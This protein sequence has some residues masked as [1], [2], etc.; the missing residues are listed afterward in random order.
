PPACQP[1]IEERP[2]DFT[3]SPGHMALQARA[4]E[5]TEKHLFPIE[6]EV[7]DNDALSPESRKAIRDGV[8]NYGFNA[9]NHDRADG[10]QGFSLVEQ[11]LVFEEFGKATNMLGLSPWMPAYCLRFGTQEQKEQYLRPAIRGEIREAFLVTEPQ[12][13]SDAG[14]ILT[15]AVRDGDHYVFNGLKCFSSGS[16]S[17]DYMLLHCNVDGDPAKATLF[18]LDKGM[19]GFEIVKRPKAMYN[20]PSQ[21]PWVQLTDLRV[22]ES[23]IL[24]GI[25]QGFELTKDWFVEQRA[26]I[27]ARCAELAATYAE[28]RKAFGRKIAEFQGIE[29]KLAEMAVDIMAA[30]ALLYRC[31]SEYDAGLDRKAAHARMSALK[32]FCTEMAWRTADQAPDPGRPRLH[33]G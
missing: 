19:A 2:M 8:L 12:S 32:L 22:H 13:G 31:A 4:R 16:E 23:K 5:F 1:S 29:W 15:S 17:A 14:G 18:I 21:H 3:F 33:D 9:V 7:Q 28:E 26:N 20:G 11:C 6:Q 30:K 27:A 10:G 25:G 24:G